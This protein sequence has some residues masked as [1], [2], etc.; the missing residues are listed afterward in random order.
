[1]LKIQLVSRNKFGPRAH[2]TFPRDVPRGS[3]GGMRLCVQIVGACT[4][5]IL[6]DK[7]VQNLTS[8]SATSIANIVGTDNAVD[9]LITALPQMFSLIVIKR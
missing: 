4:P 6:K 7:N 1:M 5:K 3:L 2:E 8:F 9:K